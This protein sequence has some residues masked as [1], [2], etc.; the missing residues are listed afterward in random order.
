MP[1]FVLFLNTNFWHFNKKKGKT[2]KIPPLNF[3]N[4]VW[5]TPPKFNESTT[6]Q[7]SLFSRLLLFSI[8]YLI[9]LLFLN[10]G[11]NSAFL[12]IFFIISLYYSLLH[13]YIYSFLLFLIY[14]NI[15]NYT[16]IIFCLH[17]YFSILWISFIKLCF[18]ANL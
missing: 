18:K 14:L 13:V 4:T 12:F 6:V 5:P 15:T 10:V 2:N 16:F 17:Y 11:F 8:Y 1:Y 9:P 3:E 7:E